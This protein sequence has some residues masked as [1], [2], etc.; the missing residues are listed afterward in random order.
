MMKFT[1][2][3]RIPSKKNSRMCFARGGKIFNIPSKAYR[4]WE[5]DA[6]LHLPDTFIDKIKKITITIYA[7]D[8]RKADLTNKAESIMDLM[9]SKKLIE[10]DSWWCVPVVELRFGGL[11]KAKPRAEIIIT[12]EP[13][14]EE[15]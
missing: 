5:I 2:F 1:I 10:D 13:H 14:N 15:T 3:G 9:V 6:S 7:P 8:K 4:Q 12:T 11:D